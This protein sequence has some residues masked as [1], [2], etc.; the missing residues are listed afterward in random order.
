MSRS[1]ALVT[2]A[3]GAMPEFEM[4]HPIFRRYANRHAMD[5]VSIRQR[6]VR[7]SPWWLWPRRRRWLYFE[8]YQMGPLLERYDRLIYADGDV[9]LTTECPNLIDLVP[10]GQLGCVFEDSG[11]LWWQRW[12]ELARAQRRLGALPG[13]PDGYFNAGVMVLSRAHRV[14]FDLETCPPV[15]GRWPMQTTINYHVHRLGLPLRPLDPRCNLLAQFTDLWGN[16]ARRRRAWA[17]H[18]AGQRYRHLMAE[19]WP[20]VTAA[21][22]TD[23]R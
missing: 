22:A 18:Y 17:I 14:L 7:A 19:D 8:K 13:K 23:G 9:L 10:A 15:G 16:A 12:E 3:I 20:H 5:F 4:S 1:A 6:R 11:P 21:W 2:L